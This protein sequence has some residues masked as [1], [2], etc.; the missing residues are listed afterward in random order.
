MERVTNVPRPRRAP[1]ERPEP[2]GRLVRDAAGR[3]VDAWLQRA[4]ERLPLTEAT[5]RRARTFARAGHPALQT[6]LRVDR[7]AGEL[8]LEAPRGL[9]AD[10]PL[11]AP[12]LSALRAALESLHREGAVHGCVDRAHVH[13]GP[14]EDVILTFARSLGAHATADRSIA[15]ARLG[16]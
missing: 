6:V 1:S 8:W 13:V 7:D 14:D 5:L 11:S 3:D 2:S 9:P 12:E 10:R 15:L 16:A 4:V